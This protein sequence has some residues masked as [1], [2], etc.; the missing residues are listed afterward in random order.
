MTVKTISAVKGE[1]NDTNLSV[2]LCSSFQ[3][4]EETY[5]TGGGRQEGS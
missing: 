1:G 5:E 3:R 2:D 4:T